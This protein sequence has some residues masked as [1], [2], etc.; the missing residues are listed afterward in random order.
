MKN[1]L[2]KTIIVTIAVGALVSC[3][4]DLK[5][6]VSG[7][8]SI[9]VTKYV[10]I[11]NSITSGFADGALYYE[12]QQ[13]SYANLLAEQFKTIGGGD[14]NTPWTPMGT[15]GIGSSLNAK[16]VLGYKTDCQGVNGLSPVPAAPGYGDISIFSNNISAQGPFNNMGVPGAKAITVVYP[17]YGDHTKPAGS[18]NPF[19]T[20]MLSSSEE[21]TASMLSKAAAQNPTFFSVFIGNNDVLSNALD[22]GVSTTPITPSAG[23]IGIGFDASY[24]LIIST[25]M[26]NGAK[27]VVAN[28]PDITNIPHFTTVPYNGLTLTATDVAN[29]NAA[30]GATGATFKE[31]S[32]NAFM[33][34]DT[35]FLPYKVRQIKS[36]EYI[37]LGTPQDSLKC[38][39]WGTSKPLADKYVLNVREVLNLKEA[40]A[41]YNAKIKTVAEE[42]GLAFVDVNAFMANAK[43][44]IVYNGITSSA[45]FVSGGAFS[46]DGIH[47]TPRGNAMLA[48]EFI[49]AINATYGSTINLVDV[50]KYNGVIFP[51][52]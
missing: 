38:A 15:Q 46:L 10:A 25:I 16:L 19:F 22:G 6:P 49:K 20:R 33:I 14:F 12:G 42:K 34:V 4:P 29:L 39:H 36:N 31:G 52:P 30:Y 41:A 28:I 40:A 45:A 17:G 26:A 51:N 21:A 44:G 37:L 18:F 23:G 43:K 11:G 13:V 47:L 8:G 1:I 2:N 7:K 27:G 32:G 3:K 24:D 50:T 35:L 48:N 5:A 9:D